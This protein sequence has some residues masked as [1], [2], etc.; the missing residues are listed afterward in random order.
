MW[1]IIRNI[2]KCFSITEFMTYLMQLILPFVCV[3]S[4]PEF[5]NK[6]NNIIYFHRQV[7]RVHLVAADRDIKPNRH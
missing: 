4:L 7:R 2:R 1:C 6:I 5:R 3:L